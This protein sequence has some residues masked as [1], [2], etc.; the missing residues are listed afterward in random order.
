MQ[1]MSY[2][3]SR[4]KGWLKTA[5]LIYT[6]RGYRGFAR[7]ITPCAMRAVPACASMFATVDIVRQ[8]LIG[9]VDGKD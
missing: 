1:F 5:Q 8:T 2:K 4:R 9:I 7:G 6:E 3:E